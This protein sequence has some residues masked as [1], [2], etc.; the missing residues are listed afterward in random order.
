M[1]ADSGV[2][3]DALGSGLGLDPEVFFSLFSAPLEG[4]LA[5]SFAA[6]VLRL[7]VFGASSAMSCVLAIDILATRNCS[8]LGMWSDS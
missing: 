3:V 6:L 1:P 2:F 4:A 8:L 7:R 5:E